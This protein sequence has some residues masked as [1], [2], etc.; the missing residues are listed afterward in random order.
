VAVMKQ[1]NWV[2]RRRAIAGCHKGGGP[3]LNDRT[4]GNSGYMVNKSSQEKRRKKRKVNPKRKRVTRKRKRWQTSA[5]KKR[6]YGERGEGRILRLSIKRGGNRV[7]QEFPASAVTSKR[8]FRGN[9]QLQLPEA[10]KKKGG[11]GTKEDQKG[12]GSLGISGARSSK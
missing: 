7:A 4:S 6:I 5:G 12:V 10:W 11:L 1:R 8:D 3:H 9:E 2:L